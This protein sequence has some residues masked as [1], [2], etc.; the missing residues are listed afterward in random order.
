MK[1]YVG[2]IDQGTTSTRFILFNYEGDVCFSH[3]VEHTQI[4][5]QPGYVEH[6]PIAIWENTC[7][8]IEETLKK[9]DA[10][11]K[12]VASVGITNQRETIIAWNKKT[13]KPYYN[14]IVWQDLRGASLINDL[15]AVGGQDR[16]RKR[17]GLPLSPYFSASKLRWLFDNCP[18]LKKDAELGDAIVGTIDTWIL[19]NLTGGVAGGVHA[20]D[21]TNA[22][23]YLLMDINKMEWSDHLLN[24]FG[25]PKNVLPKIVSSVPVCPYGYSTEDGPFKGPVAVAGILGDQQAAL[26]GQTCFRA[27]M[28]KST[29]GTGG[30][31]LMNTGENLVYSEHGL[32]TTVAYKIGQNPVNYALEGSVAVA[33]SLVQWIRDNLGLIEKSSDIDKMAASVEDNGGVYFVPAFSGLYAPYWKAKARG[34]ICG[35]TGFANKNHIARAAL[36]STAFQ[37]YDIFQAMSNDADIDIPEL[38]VDGGL[39]NSEPLMQF[40]ADLLGIDVI[41]PK[42]YETTALGAAYAAGLSVGFWKSK[43]DLFQNWKRD[44]VWQ[45]NMDDSKKAKF[46]SDWKKAINKS[47]KWAE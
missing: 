22:S 26:F 11:F 30:F 5:P 20:T 19:W 21:V 23:R 8:C 47:C 14:A 7:I 46:L 45:P 38:K 31:L 12:D 4:F 18:D 36:E 15:S 10:T 35:L 2:S 44:K 42:V 32:I 29:Y 16:F 13:G 34:I 39:T 25:I 43:E 9:A 6:D 1:K 28:S 41:R 37:T 17:T 27:G 24:V 40:Q 33:G 3:Q